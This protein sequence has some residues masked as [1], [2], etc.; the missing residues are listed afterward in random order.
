MFIDDLYALKNR[1]PERL[2]MHF[3]FSREEQ[4]FPIM[5][6]RL[7]ADKV[8]ELYSAFVGEATP[9]AAYVCGPDTMIATVSEALVALG[10]SEDRVHVERSTG[11]AVRGTP[12]R[13]RSAWW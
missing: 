3:L 12:K 7:E 9:D 6:G 13:S 1:F 8:R 4:E 2:Q 11:F 5:S 10:V